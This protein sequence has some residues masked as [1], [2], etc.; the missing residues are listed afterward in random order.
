MEKPRNDVS[1]IFSHL[2]IGDELHPRGFTRV[3]HRAGAETRGRI[4]NCGLIAAKGKYAN[5][6]SFRL[7]HR[8][9][10]SPIKQLRRYTNVLK[11]T[12][13]RLGCLP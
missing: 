4:R 2:T 9:L 12:E 3:G 13:W 8:V 10:R 7:E 5:T 1:G 6:L 11:R